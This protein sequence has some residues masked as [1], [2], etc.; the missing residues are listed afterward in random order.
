MLKEIQTGNV[1]DVGSIYFT[2]LLRKAQV[3]WFLFV[4]RSFFE[5]VKDIGTT[6]NFSIAYK[7]VK[8]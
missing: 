2:G 4:Y 8:A 6:V 7:I 3:K 1:Q 5:N